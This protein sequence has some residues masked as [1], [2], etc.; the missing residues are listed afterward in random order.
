MPAKPPTRA[1]GPD[2]IWMRED[3]AT[4]GKH[5]LHAP[6]AL[7]S[8][9]LLI[10]GSG[11]TSSKASLKRNEI[12]SRIL[13][14]FSRWEGTPYRLGGTSR[15][16]LDCSAFVQHVYADAFGLSMPRTVRE[17]VK[18]GYPINPSELQ[19][20]DL[21]FF[22]PS[23]VARHVGI[24]LS[25]RTFTH[26]ST[27]QGVVVSTLDQAYWQSSYWASRRVLEGTPMFAQPTKRPK[28]NR[29]PERETTVTPTRRTGW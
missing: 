21:V 5:S 4:C 11:C 19:A 2:S 28:P 16:G 9:V 12:E 3:V 22:Q 26:A 1:H 24:Y 25:D 10:G 13:E 20:G 29:K 8:M 7:V 14:Q 27:S 18:V 15:K 17:Q 23:G 6:V